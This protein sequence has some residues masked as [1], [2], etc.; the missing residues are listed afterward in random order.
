MHD[1][2]QCAPLSTAA[3]PAIAP[4]PPIPGFYD[5]PDEKRPFVRRVFDDAAPDYNRVERMMALGSGS[6]YR[7]RA[8]ARAGLQRGMRVLDVAAGT[9]LVTRE[10]AAIAGDASLVLG[11]D[12]SSGMLGE[13]VRSLPSVRFALGAAESL[14]VGDGAVDFLSMGYALRHVSDLGVTFREYFRVLR[15]GGRACVLEITRPD[16]RVSTA[17]L[18]L[19]M[20]WVVPG[21]TR[22]AAA[23]AKSHRLWSYYWDT[24]EQCLPPEGIMAAM[25]AAGFVDVRRHVE[26]GIFSEYTGR[27]P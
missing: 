25:T 10:A 13:A 12:P 18:R 2:V 7:R 17:F 6:W 3:V 22:L 26:L 16:G 24:I 1:P 19:Y 21:L 5:R 27:K 15:P 23:R 20:R 11:V 14:P 8:L 9:G 4:H